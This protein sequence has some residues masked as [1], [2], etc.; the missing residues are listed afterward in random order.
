MLWTESRC[1]SDAEAGPAARGTRETGSVEIGVD[2]AGVAGEACP[3]KPGRRK[4]A[5]DTLCVVLMPL[6]PAPDNTKARPM[7]S[8][9]GFQSN[10]TPH[11]RSGRN[12]GN[13]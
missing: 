1:G 11:I 6:H 4:V 13:S 8:R 10:C 2:T 12:D 3:K 5:G 7:T 9:A